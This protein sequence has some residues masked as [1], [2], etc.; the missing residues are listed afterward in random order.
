MHSSGFFRIKF[1]A[2]LILKHEISRSH[3]ISDQSLLLSTIVL[4]DDCQYSNYI[5]SYIALFESITHIHY[6]TL[7]LNL[8]NFLY[9]LI[10]R[11]NSIKLLCMQLSITQKATYQFKSVYVAMTIQVHTYVQQYVCNSRTAKLQLYIY[12][13]NKNT[14]GVKKYGTN[15]KQHCKQAGTTKTFDIS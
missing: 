3:T 7:T 14:W 8:H 2:R 10:K 12:M 11:P 15:Q 5:R 9:I 1:I 13:L 4:N 6:C